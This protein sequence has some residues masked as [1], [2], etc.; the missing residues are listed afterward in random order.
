MQEIYKYQH[1]SE[2]PITLCEAFVRKYL[3]TKK[4]QV[5]MQIRRLY[6]EAQLI[7]DNLHQT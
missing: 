5:C 3:N 4:S 7:L 1:G 2:K 6:E